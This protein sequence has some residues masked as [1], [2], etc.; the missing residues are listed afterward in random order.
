MVERDLF[1]WLEIHFIKKKKEGADKRI[2]LRMRNVVSILNLK[3]LFRL[4]KLF[5]FKPFD[6]KR[7][8][9]YEMLTLMMVFVIIIK[10]LC[11]QNMTKQKIYKELI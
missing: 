6:F 5:V 4:I 3:V 1:F 9:I 10:M 11:T 7:L 2:L 8:H